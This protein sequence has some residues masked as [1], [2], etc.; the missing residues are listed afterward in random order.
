MLSAGCKIFTYIPRDEKKT[1]RDVDRSIRTCTWSDVERDRSRCMHSL[2]MH[3][4]WD[5]GSE[6]T[7]AKGKNEKVWKKKE[8][9]AACHY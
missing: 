5:G 3:G 2:I 4:V 6:R 9:V 1:R 7:K 8:G